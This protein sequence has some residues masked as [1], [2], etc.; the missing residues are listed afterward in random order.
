MSGLVFWSS[1]FWIASAVGLVLLVWT[2]REWRIVPFGLLLLVLALESHFTKG[3]GLPWSG[4]L[5]RPL[6][7]G[8]EELEAVVVASMALLGTIV[9]GHLVMSGAGRGAAG[10]KSQDQLERVIDALP[11]LVG[12]VSA[13]R[14]YSLVNRQ[15][16]AYLGRPKEALVGCRIE[17]VFKA[18]DAEGL[19]PHVDAALKGQDHRFRITLNFPNLGPR[20]LEVAYVSDRDESGAIKGFFILAQDISEAGRAERALIESEQRFRDLTEIASDWFWETDRQGRFSYISP[21]LQETTGIPAIF[22]LGMRPRD[23]SGAEGGDA[24]WPELEEAFQ[25]RKA[26]RNI[27]YRRSLPDGRQR[28]FQASGRPVFGDDGLFRG[29]RGVCSDITEQVALVE[30]R[31]LAELRFAS[32]IESMPEAFALYDRNDRLVSRNLVHREFYEAPCGCEDAIGQSFEE[33]L[34]GF[35]GHGGVAGEPNEVEAWIERRLKRRQQPAHRL[36][37]P[38]CDGRWLEVTDFLLF[39][40]TVI[41]ITADVTALEQADLERRACEAEVAQVQRRSLMGEMAAVLAHEL[42]Q[43]LSAVVT[44][45]TGF[46]RRIGRRPPSRSETTKLLERIANEAGRASE[47]LRSI[48]TFL[49][50]SEMRPES[51]DVEELFA[52]VKLLARSELQAGEVVAR[53]RVE[54][55]L[56][57]LEAVRIE[58]EQVLLNLIRNAIEAL[59]EV[60]SS[61]RRLTLSAAL[62]EKNKLAITISD[63]GRGIPAEIASAAFNAFFTTKAD[64][65]GMGLAISRRIA[66]GHGGNLRILRSEPGDTSLCLTLPIDGSKK[67]DELRAA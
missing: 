37:F 34:R 31:A 28:L 8:Y 2:Y 29:Y 6:L 44:Y 50:S 41:S 56:P 12:Y 15:M 47:M 54:S 14:R 61:Q 27:A 60:P 9:L 59:Q 5:D 1:A 57:A 51:I 32:A 10:A 49:G 16:A 35:A 3:S 7:E 66:Q 13:E 23:R 45:A 4:L 39:D 53:F 30:R 38:T 36:R 63:N 21:R 67:G 33:I 25:E 19:F 18:E 42:N 17:D 65:L 24:D 46:I 64:G 43:P 22:S 58:I 55:G 48:G 40:E 11:A 52:S 26:F 62:S 20:Q